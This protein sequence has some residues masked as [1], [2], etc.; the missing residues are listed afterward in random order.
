MPTRKTTRKE[1][2]EQKQQKTERKIPT[3]GNCCNRQAPRDC[4]AV[5]FIAEAVAGA[6]TTTQKSKHDEQEKE[7]IDKPRKI[8]Y[9]TKISLSG[10][11]KP[12]DYLAAHLAVEAVAGADPAE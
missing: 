1:N 7:S 9:P 11:Q 3:D 5:I 4:L 8:P 6:K 10:E 12:S 2:R